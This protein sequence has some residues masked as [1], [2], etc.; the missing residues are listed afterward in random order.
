MGE[1]VFFDSSG[2]RGRKFRRI[3]V[4]IATPTTAYLVIVVN[5]LL[6]GPRI[7]APLIPLP[8]TG[9]PRAV[10]PVADPRPMSTRVHE[11]TTVREPRVTTLPQT[12]LRAGPTTTGPTTAA[13]IV[14]PTPPHTNPPPR[15]RGSR[16]SITGDHSS[17][18]ATSARGGAAA[19]SHSSKPVKKAEKVKEVKKT[20]PAKKAMFTPVK[21]VKART[22]PIKPSL[23]GA[24]R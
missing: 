18:P 22:V 7:D 3:A 21:K 15:S 13:G 23:K 2:G 6:G 14:A 11:R 8:G 17:T 1:P 16:P 19:K 12:G 10:R 9:E 20:T 24:E 5:S 4:L